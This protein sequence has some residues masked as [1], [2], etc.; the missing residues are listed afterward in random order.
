MLK[1]NREIKIFIKYLELQ[2]MKETFEAPTIC[3]NELLFKKID[4]RK[5]P[6]FNSLNLPV[7]IKGL[8]FDLQEVRKRNRPIRMRLN[9]TLKRLE[10]YLQSNGPSSYKYWRY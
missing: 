6:L 1:Y 8:S 7:L 2:I 3:S 4:I 9:R 10:V 5:F